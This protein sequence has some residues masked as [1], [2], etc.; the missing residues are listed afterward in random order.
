MSSMSDR[1]VKLLYNA[2]RMTGGDPSKIS[3]AN[4]FSKSGEKATLI[5]IA[6]GELDPEQAAIWRVQEGK[7]ISVATAAECLSGNPLSPTAQADLWEH[8]PQYVR[9][10]IAESAKAEERERASLDQKYQESRLR[11]RIHACNGDERMAREQIRLEDLND[12]SLGG[13][14][15]VG[16]MGGLV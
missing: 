1:E 15:N 7:G 2:V 4:P 13:Q 16:V 11:N 10:A 9:E 12:P 8:D 5:Q 6:C 3:L 14:K